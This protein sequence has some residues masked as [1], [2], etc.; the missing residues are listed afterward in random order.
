MEE[1]EHTIAHL[2]RALAKIGCKRRFGEDEVLRLGGNELAEAD[3]K[4]IASAGYVSAVYQKP[5]LTKE[6]AFESLYFMDV[7][8]S[9]EELK[10]A[11]EKLMQDASAGHVFRVKGFLPKEDGTWLELNA[12][13]K[14]ITLCPIENGQE[15]LIV[16]GEDLVEEKIRAYWNFG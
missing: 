2:N 4:K 1:Q 15:I 9:E 10:N 8:M 12:T 7:H 6:Q 5:D 3:F 16:I 14:E 13:S 11:V